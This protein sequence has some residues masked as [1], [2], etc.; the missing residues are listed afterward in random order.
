MPP[1]DLD[2]IE[3]FVSAFNAVDFHLQGALGESE[4][5]SFRSLVDLYARRHRWWRDAEQLRV[6]AS[7][8]NVIIHDKVEPYEYVCVPTTRTVEDLE[9]IRE[10]LRTPERIDPRFCRAVVTLEAGDSLSKVLKL[11][12]EREITHFPV[13]HGTKFSGL[14]TTNGITRYLAHH[15]AKNG[16]PLDFDAVEVRFVLAREESR[17]NFFFAARD[18]PVQKIAFA[19]HENTF[20]EAVLITPNGGKQEKLLG[21]ATRADVLEFGL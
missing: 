6:F 11:V 13:Y 14:L 5:A 12:H 16:A 8:R 15:A 20:L 19:F 4:R 17:A 1:T 7:L 9:A 21:I 2:L 10:R 3:R 18:E